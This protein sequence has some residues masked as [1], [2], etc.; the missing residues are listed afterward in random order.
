MSF[1][2]AANRASCVK[3]AQVRECN[4]QHNYADRES[5][6]PIS[7]REVRVVAADN[8][9]EKKCHDADECAEEEP[10]ETCGETHQQRRKPAEITE[11]DAKEDALLAGAGNIMNAFHL[12]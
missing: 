5:D 10:C 6:V 7:V 3:N 2:A 1:A 12:K 8:A 9:V 4:D 11:R